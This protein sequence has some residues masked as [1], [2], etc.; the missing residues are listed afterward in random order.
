V[1][2]AIGVGGGPNVIG[3]QQRTLLQRAVIR[4]LFS[5][6]GYR[7]AELCGELP[8]DAFYENPGA[9][10]L[11]DVAVFSDDERISRT[12]VLKLLEARGCSA[13][14]IDLALHE[15]DIA[16]D[17]SGLYWK[18]D[19]GE[20]FYQG[21]LLKLI[22]DVRLRGQR[23]RLMQALRAIGNG[24]VGAVEAILHDALNF[25][26]HPP[27]QYGVET[28]D[29]YVERCLNELLRG[30]D[31]IS[32]SGSVLAPLL[33]EMRYG[34]MMVIG[35]R[36]GVGKT[37]MAVQLAAELS[38]MHSL[39]VMFVTLEM[40]SQ[41]IFRRFAQHF[42]RGE[43]ERLLRERS[44]AIVVLLDAHAD[45]MRNITLVEQPAARPEDIEVAI[46]RASPKPSVVIVDY[47]Q[48]MSPSSYVRG[49]SSG[50]RV[51]EL[52]EITRR[53]KALA[54]RE[55]IALVM[56]AQLNRRVEQD[57]RST[58]MLSDLRDSGTIEQD[59]DYVLF[60]ARCNGGD[61]SVQ[62]AKNRHGAVGEMMC[63]FDGEAMTFAFEG[64]VK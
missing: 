1:D 10:L 18:S 22:E 59:A 11:Y 2:E 63:L 32:L 35:A 42:T 50:N 12:D 31:A 61:V 55:K 41:Q 19:L 56:L 34:D 47:L 38:G 46:R 58:I 6:D 25:I 21:A 43:S 8:R 9:G 44:D 14:E 30:G 29:R 54:M 39:P 16:L 7:R 51:Q 36:P 28:L 45:V 17:S 52:G 26:D 20:E 53:M 48:L 33:H 13:R 64:M 49:K 37:A 5:M 60:L 62:L 24:D 40:S 15:F 4:Y 23:E 3:R 27:V 57:G